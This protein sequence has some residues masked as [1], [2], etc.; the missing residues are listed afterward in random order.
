MNRSSLRH[1]LP[2]LLVLCAVAAAPATAAELT[3]TGPDGARV[4]LNGDPVGTLPLFEP[5]DI[6]IGEY[7]VEATL[8]G[9][10]DIVRELTVVEEGEVLALH[11]RFTPM[12]RTTAV[13]SSLLLA[14]SG[15]RQ[16]GRDRL[17]WILTGAEVAGLLTALAGELQISNHESDYLRSMEAYNNA[18]TPD[19]IAHWRA[20]ADHHHDSMTSAADR[21]DL[22]LMLAAGAV[23]VSVV[24]SWLSFPSLDADLTPDGT[25]RL[26]LS[27]DF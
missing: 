14:G 22:A 5:L 26:G 7:L 17:G 13:V 2:A 19:A 25:A 4:S 3:L 18:V 23:L 24:D 9:A 16:I 15:Q 11:L 27:L 10:H 6:A 1:V 12:S 20:Q 21:R 8:P